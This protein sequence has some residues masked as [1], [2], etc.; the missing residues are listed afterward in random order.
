MIIKGIVVFYVNVKDMPS[1]KVENVITQIQQKVNEG[2][3]LTRLKNNG[4]E[5]M[6]VPCHDSPT[7]VEMLR[8]NSL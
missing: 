7:R 5:N 2:D 3:L 6:W 1:D 8:I 4:Y